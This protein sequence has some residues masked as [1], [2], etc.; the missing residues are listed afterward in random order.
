[1]SKDAWDKLLRSVGIHT[2][3]VR[4]NRYNQVIHLV[5]AAD[6]AEDYYN[7]EDN[8]TRTE[9]VELARVIDRATCQAWVGH[10]YID[11]ID[12]STAFEEKLTRMLSVSMILMLIASSY[13]CFV[14]S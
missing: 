4:D 5:T 9:G 1:M 6:G 7:C 11:I 14:H 2:V 3:D 13:N 8:P 12:N 10:P